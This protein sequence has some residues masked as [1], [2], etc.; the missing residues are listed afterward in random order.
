MSSEMREMPA[1][2]EIKVEGG[3]EDTMPNSSDNIN[4]YAELPNV[5]IKTEPDVSDLVIKTEAPYAFMDANEEPSHIGHVGDNEEF[6]DVN[7][8][9]IK[10]EPNFLPDGD[11]VQFYS[12]ECV[13]PNRSS[14]H[15]SHPNSLSDYA[16]TGA[17]A[18]YTVMSLMTEP[19][20]QM[21]SLSFDDGNGAYSDC[22]FKAVVENVTLV[23]DSEGRLQGV[24][25]NEED[26]SQDTVVKTEVDV[27]RVW[28]GRLNGLFHSGSIFPTN[29]SVICS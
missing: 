4:V 7:N 17:E 22:T 23:A 5:G 2:I 25:V 13:E 29:L 1:D 11:A 27:S 8:L 20:G 16:E 21:I 6:T 14:E 18:P 15:S 26:V 10:M 12:E 28:G 19:S 3:R 9:N 24:P